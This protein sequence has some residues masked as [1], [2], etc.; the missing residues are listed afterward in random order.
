M[1]NTPEALASGV[2]S[3]RAAMIKVFRFLDKYLE[4]S[5]IVCLLAY[6]V[7]GVNFEVFRRYILN[8]SGAYT[9]EAIRLALIAMVYLGV[10]YIIKKRKH[11]ACDVFSADISP[12]K[13]FV[14]NTIGN[15]F[16]LLFS[17][18]MTYATF[19]LIEMQL[20]L[21][22]KTEA[23]HLPVAFF[24]SIM[25]IGFGLSIIRLI[26]NIYEDITKLKKTTA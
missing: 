20:M 6:L 9:E 17:C 7:L 12:K 23:M 19:H 15:L 1:K 14:L 11:I 21:D 8:R 16:F 26:Q 4:E 5:V 25:L 22:K 3:R 2:F 18:I 24:T 13:D 10:P